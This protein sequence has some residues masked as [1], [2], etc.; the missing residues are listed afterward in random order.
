V[1]QPADPL[2]RVRIAPRDGD[3]RQHAVDVLLA[4]QR[5]RFVPDHEP[6]GVLDGL[7]VLPR[8]ELRHQQPWEELR[9]VLG[10]AS[11]HVV[12]A[13]VSAEAE[14][15]GERVQVSAR[16]EQAR[17][18]IDA[19]ALVVRERRPR[20]IHAEAKVDR[21]E[22]GVAQ[23]QVERARVGRCRGHGFVLQAPTY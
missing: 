13:P 16:G 7:R 4:A 23:T 17:D 10:E 22:V 11:L 14:G 15:N 21:P 5:R 8:S 20:V 6:R 2:K 12:D 19:P 18:L 3:H 9:P 1:L